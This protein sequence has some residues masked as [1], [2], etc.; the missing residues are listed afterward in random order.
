MK[1]NHSGRFATVA[2]SL[3]AQLCTSCVSM[4]PERVVANQQSRRQQEEQG[5]S[6]PESSA[7]QKKADEKAFHERLREKS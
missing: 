3:A 6:D 7:V 5:Y 2:L 1:R 4:T